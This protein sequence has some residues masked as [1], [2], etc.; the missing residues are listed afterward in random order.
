M[1]IVY[2]ETQK[3]TEKTFN[4]YFN[5]HGLGSKKGNLYFVITH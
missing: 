2:F 5:F 1:L 3:N 4:Y